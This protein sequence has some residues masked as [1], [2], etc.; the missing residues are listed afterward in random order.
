MARESPPHEESIT[1]PSA[2]FKAYQRELEKNIREITKEAD[3]YKMHNETL[4]K[5]REELLAENENLRVLLERT[6]VKGGLSSSWRKNI[7][8]RWSMCRSK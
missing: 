4:K 6:Q 1:Y 3:T 2:E 5:E 8:W 7:A